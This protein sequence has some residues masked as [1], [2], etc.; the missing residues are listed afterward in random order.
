MPQINTVTHKVEFEFDPGSGSWTDM[1]DYMDEESGISFSRGVGGDRKMRASSMSF[2][3]DNASEDLTIGNSSSTYFNKLRKGIGVRYSWTYSGTTKYEF[4][5][6]VTSIKPTFAH[7]GHAGNRVQFDCEGQTS[8]LRKYTKYG[9]ALQT[10]V[11]VDDA[12]TAIMTACGQAS[13]LYSFADSSLLI[14]YVF[15]R[16]DALTDL[17]AVAQSDPGMLLFEDGQGRLRL[18][19]VIGGNHGSPDHTWGGSGNP[20][21]EGNVSPDY[22]NDSQNA[23]A[24]VEVSTLTPSTVDVELYRHSLNVDAGFLERFEARASRKIKGEFS[25]MP[26]SVVTQFVQTI[27]PFN[28]TGGTLDN[29][30]NASTT[31]PITVLNAF[32]ALVPGEKIRID[33]E[34]MEITAVTHSGQNG[35]LGPWQYLTVTRAQMGTLAAAHGTTIPQGNPVYRQQATEVLSQFNPPQYGVLNISVT[36][37][38][39]QLNILYATNIAVNDYIKI[40]SEIVRVT[41]LAGANFYNVARAQYGSTAAAHTKNALCYKRTLRVDGSIFGTSWLQGSDV[42]DGHPSVSPD[43]VG[44][45][46]FPNAQH[47]IWDGNKFVAAIYNNSDGVR[48][49]ADMVIGGK[50]L[51]LAEGKAKIAYERAI[52]YVFGIPEASALPMPFGTTDVAI[53]KAYAAGLLFS[54]R[55]PTPWLELTFT[56]NESTKT[57]SMLTAEIGD[58]VRYTG[59]G[60]YREKVDEWYRILGVKGTLGADDVMRLSFTLAPSHLWRNPALCHLTDFGVTRGEYNNNLG[61]F[62]IQPTGGSGWSQDTQWQM[63]YFLGSTVSTPDKAYAPNVANPNAALVNVGSADGSLATRWV[64]LPSNNNTYTT[65]TGGFGITFRGNTSTATTYWEARFNPTQNLIY[66]W[67]TTDGVVTG[68]SVAWTATNAPEME[69]RCQGD[70]IRVFVDCNAEPVIDV[71]NSRFNTG[72]YAGP[73]LRRTIVTGGGVAPYLLFFYAHAL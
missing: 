58:L 73:S 41:S 34:V 39:T 18:K 7:Y 14:P 19:S 57:A 30:I 6:Y 54:G 53:A 17:V 51:Q 13:A 16:G 42:A 40:D 23:R 35:S 32:F 20:Q 27:S 70:R 8:F 52:P 65:T 47:I 10:G 64:N 49:M 1:A 68:G 29:S 2:S 25:A 50:A 31:G 45:G 37:S 62:V 72:T 55:V 61:G 44:S 12:L 36:T 22:Q 24:S 9:M 3:M 26:T 59:T 48:Y 71:T 11:D 38:A 5:G 15:P 46:I 28:W 43:I 56:V 66:L 67:N 63:S 21:P 60:Q 4:R 69:V 33:N